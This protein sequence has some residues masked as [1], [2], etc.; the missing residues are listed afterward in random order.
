MCVIQ[1]FIPNSA[2]YPH[3]SVLSSFQ[4]FISELNK[5]GTL[6]PAGSLKSSSGLCPSLST[7][8]SATKTNFFNELNMNSR[9]FM[10]RHACLDIKFG[11]TK[12]TQVCTEVAFQFYLVH[13][14]LS[15]FPFPFSLSVVT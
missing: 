2:F 4:R 5:T 11:F 14:V 15:S 10:S 6:P 7:Q 1:P 13:C 9:D 8:A 3:F 12:S